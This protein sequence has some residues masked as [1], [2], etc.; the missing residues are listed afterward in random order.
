MADKMKFSDNGL[1]LQCQNCGMYMTEAEVVPMPA[2]SM[3]M[4][5]A[6]GEIMP[7]GECPECGAVVHLAEERPNVAL[8]SQ[9]IWEALS[10]ECAARS[11]DDEGDRAVTS[12]VVARALERAGI[13]V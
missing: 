11:M 4:R 12:V 2:G 3:F 5:V 9:R 10:E 7:Y 1:A 8:A 6:P 13:L